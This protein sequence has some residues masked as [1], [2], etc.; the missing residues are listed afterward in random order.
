MRFSL[1]FLLA[2]GIVFAAEP[3]ISCGELSDAPQARLFTVVNQNS[4][5]IT[6]FYENLSADPSR[7]PIADYILL[8]EV[9][10]N[11][12]NQLEFYRI[13]LDSQGHAEYD[14]SSLSDQCLAFKVLY[15]PFCDPESPA[16]GFEACLNYS[17]I[18][19]GA[20]SVND[21]PVVPGQSVPGT[22]NDRRFLPALSQR[23]YCPPPP[24]LGATPSM[25]FPLLL[26][27][28]LLAGS[29]YLTG[30]NPFA[31]LNVGGARMGRHIKYQARGR[32]YAF[33]TMAAVSAG[34]SVGTAVKTLA[35]SGGAG[36][37]NLE[38]RSAHAR[39]LGGGLMQVGRGVGALS[40]A[41][42][43]AAGKKGKE[44][45]ETMTR[46]MEAGT[47]MWTQ[48]K[49]MSAKEK[50]MTAQQT[51]AGTM[52]HLPG[53]GA[54]RS[55]DTVYSGGGFWGNIF[56]TMGQ[57]VLVIM[58]QTTIGRI[59][60]GYLYLGNRK[61][62]M[63]R[64]GITKHEKRMAE[65]LKAAADMMGEGQEGI[66]VNVGGTAH[67]VKKAIVDAE[68]NTVYVIESPSY[69]GGKT[70]RQITVDDKGKVVG[71]S[72]PMQVTA[73]MARNHK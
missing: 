5:E 11:E 53:G 58:T 21:V 48:E 6:A 7:L 14:F 22:L 47:S 16:C 50:S 41:K 70:T 27:F 12:G 10:D 60:D 34:I 44:R 26:I 66:I 59:V 64:L 35:E 18:E 45:S 28:S 38:K 23:S 24:P 42:R 25:C 67:V 68:G 46:T 51:G 54:V 2:L 49:G 13:Y 19:T 65:D 36:L 73:D 61:G 39:F 33:S 37:A 31:G 20:T 43:A 4:L 56:G 8:L 17:G 52:T 9:A 71:M 62:M 72:Y 55:G 63:E 57:M 1:I 69:E 32:G 3:C 40:A 29:M 30:N 15:C